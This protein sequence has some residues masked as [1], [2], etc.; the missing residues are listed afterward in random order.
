MPLNVGIVGLPNV[1]KSTIFSALTSVPAEAA[2]YPFCTIDPN[3]GIVP[4][5]DERLQR[6]TEII[7]TEKVIPTVVEFVDIAGLVRG[8]SKGEGRGNQFLAHIR[9]T[10]ILAHVVRCFDD[11]DVTHVDGS[12]DPIRDIETINIELALAD[13]E[14]VTRRRDRLEKELKSHDKKIAVAAKAF[15]P[16]L[17]TLTDHLQDGR[18][19]RSLELTPDQRA[20]I[21]DLHLLTA[22]PVLYVCNVDESGMD[23]TSPYEAL[24]RRHAAGEGAEVVRICGQLEAEIAALETEEERRAFLED[25]GLQEPG[26]AQLIRSGY[27]GLGL[28][29]FFTAGPKENRAW[30]FH[31]GATA[32]EA[33]GVIHTDFQKGFIRAETYHIEDLFTYGSE[34]KVREAGK[35]R[36]EGKEY[37]VKDGDVMFFKFN[38]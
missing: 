35:L 32:P 28:R 9:E 10:G 34:Q 29:T 21:Y 13:L 30:T 24:V 12:I 6:L 1:G 17:E 36:Q 3:V 33:A 38:V 25:A 16:V 7:P 31:E 4:V 26:L 19:A 11:D 14:T 22:K 15:Q 27:R 20:M 5:P 23:G 37:R 18:P 8:A 2:N